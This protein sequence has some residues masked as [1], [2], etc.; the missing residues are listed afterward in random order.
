MHATKDC[1]ACHSSAWHQRHWKDQNKT[2]FWGSISRILLLNKRVC[3]F[4]FRCW[5]IQGNFKVC[6]LLEHLHNSILS[7]EVMKMWKVW[8]LRKIC[9][10]NQKTWS[11]IEKEG[12]PLCHTFCFI[13]GYSFPFFFFSWYQD[14]YGSFAQIKGEWLLSCFIICWV[15]LFQST[16]IFLFICLFVYLVIYC[17]KERGFKANQS[18]KILVGLKSDQGCL[19]RT[20]TFIDHFLCVCDKDWKE[21]RK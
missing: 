10:W 16:C 4:F 2:K 19:S 8:Q 13:E 12:A 20:N 6:G 3:V 11:C 5:S 7:S 15:G 1:I 9:D 18:Y 21:Y 14:D 17:L